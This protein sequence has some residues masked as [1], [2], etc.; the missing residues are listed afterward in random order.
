MPFLI[1]NIEV[2][3]LI[4]GYIDGIDKVARPGLSERIVSNRSAIRIQFE[5]AFVFAACITDVEIAVS[6]YG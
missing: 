3:S 4:S 1:N 5:D 2:S 6:V